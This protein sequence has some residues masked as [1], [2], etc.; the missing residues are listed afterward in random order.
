MPWMPSPRLRSCSGS[1]EPEEHGGLQK[2]QAAQTW[3][4]GLCGAMQ[5]P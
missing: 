4:V 2:G 1:P 3:D 5:I